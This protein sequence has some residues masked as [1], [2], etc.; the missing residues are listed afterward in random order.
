VEKTFYKGKIVPNKMLQ[1]STINNTHTHTHTHTFECRWK[2][3]FILFSFWSI[4]K[5]I[6]LIFFVNSLLSANTLLG[7]TSILLVLCLK[8][9]GLTSQDEMANYN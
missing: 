5:K 6:Q 7:C 2:L 8:N 4:E 9:N 1:N 3:V